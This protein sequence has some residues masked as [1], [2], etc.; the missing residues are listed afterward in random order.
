M[1]SKTKGQ[2]VSVGFITNW[3]FLMLAAMIQAY[4]PFFCTYFIW[5]ALALSKVF[6]GRPIDQSKAIHW[7]PHWPIRLVNDQHAHRARNSCILC[8]SV[9]I[10]DRPA[11]DI[12]C[13][14]MI[15]RQGS[16]QLLGTQIYW[17]E[18]LCLAKIG[19][20]RNCHVMYIAC[21]WFSAQ[22]C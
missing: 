21:S 8:C 10:S 5:H 9:I 2:F 14:D 7:N 11:M 12:L 15:L 13:T 18:L 3:N 16:S 6:P 4:I 1:A 20:Q 17:A 19:Y 22:F